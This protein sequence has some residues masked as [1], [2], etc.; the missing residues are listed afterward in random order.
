[1]Y[2]HGVENRFA[3]WSLTRVFGSIKG[4]IEAAQ[5]QQFRALKYE[6]ESMR[7]RPN[8]AGC[9]AFSD[10]GPQTA[11]SSVPASA[12]VVLGF[13]RVSLIRRNVA[14]AWPTTW[15]IL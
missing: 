8:F 4:I 15:S 13:G 14:N 10:T 1:M 7:Q 3:D 11:S 9:G 6:I 2:A 12:C 5:W